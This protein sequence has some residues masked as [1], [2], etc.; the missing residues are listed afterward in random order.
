[1]AHGFLSY[2]DTRGE[3]DYLSK[4][5]KLLKK[6]QKETG[7]KGPKGSGDVELKDTPDGVEP[8]KVVEEGQ[9][10]L[11]GSGP[12]GFLKGSALSSISGK[13]PKG[14]LPQGKAIQPEVLGGA[15]SRISRKPGIDAGND[16]YDT[17]AV[18]VNDPAG[19]LS[20]I[21]ELIVRSNNNVV[22]AI[23][24][25]QRVT[26]RVVDSVENLGR[27]QA[28][29]AD[30]QMQQQML[31]ATRAEVAA[32]KRALAAGSDLSGGITAD[33]AGQGPQKGGGFLQLPGLG[34][35]PRLPMGRRG[36]PLA[37][38]AGSR[39][40]TRAATRA[41]ARTGTKGAAKIG[42]KALGK[43]LLK[44]IP[45]LGLGAGALF[46]AERAMAGDFTGAGLELA[47][48]AASTLPGLGTAASVGIDAAL[49]GRDMGLTPF[50]S[51]GII[52]QPTASLMGEAGNEGVFP[53]EGVKGKET[54]LKFG[55]GILEAQRR[56]KKESAKRMAEGL[57][58]YYDKRNGWEKFMDAL[59]DFIK[60]TPLRRF[61]N[62]GDNDDD[63]RRPGGGGRRGGGNVN[64]ANIAA[65]TAEEKAF[66]ATVRET[67]GTAGA[68]G[69]NTVYGGAVVPELTQ[70][71]LKELYDATKIGG[72]DRLP[73]R[74]GGGLIP[75][76]KDQYNST[77][78]GAVQLMPETLKGMIERGE[79][80]WDD[81]FNEETQNSMILTLARNGGIDIENITPAQLDKASGI[82][83][84]LAGTHHGQTTRTAS[85]SYKLYEE[86][87]AEANGTAPTPAGNNDDLTPD[88]EET[89]SWTENIP[90][91]AGLQPGHSG[92]LKIADGIYA[93]V[94]N[95]GDGGRWQI[96]RENWGGPDKG[97]LSTVGANN[98]KLEP[99]LK[100]RIE[101]Y[102]KDT[103]LGPQANAGNLNPAK[104]DATALSSKSTEIAM[105]TIGNGKA[106][107]INN[108]YVNGGQNGGGNSPASV[109][110]GI[111]SR[112]T[113]TSPFSDI[114][115]RTIG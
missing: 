88:F 84:G 12:K 18:R 44:K 24:G 23:M 38:R 43:G 66:I 31:L 71:T 111:S 41:G 70:M 99:L 46:A 75:F 79:F 42:A 1:M 64:A 57:A 80:S 4:I 25:V 48:G 45:L 72:H 19:S 81:I 13:D 52:T 77:A 98:A 55:E 94:K 86:N 33:E 104:D 20:G 6:R 17:T 106:T 14:A 113:G 103:G 105:A 78:S 89:P 108:T 53:L 109:P 9:K 35:I 68:Q 110:I 50:A 16:V 21:G 51:G 49:A 8:V 85:Q 22:E 39:G 95:D 100:K 91:P 69:Y 58:E 59:K 65:D 47:S 96:Y 27:L 93:R 87:L 90:F 101:Q 102:Q 115:L 107:I 83:A 112:D 32:E 11:L 7:K 36:G 61:F 26:V 30:K 63:D 29:I 34:G 5:G 40:L 37:R 73:E 82:W 97:E 92:G 54:F 3:V 67:E 56:N 60:G 114:N 62:W 28:A 74:L 76:K 10:S 2:Q 15:L